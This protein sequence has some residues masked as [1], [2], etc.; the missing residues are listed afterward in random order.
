MPVKHSNDEYPLRVDD[1]DEAV[2]PDDKLS[3]PREFRIRNLVA[4]IG[5]PRKRFGGVNGKLGQVGGIGLGVPGD[6]L[7]GRFQVLDGGVSPD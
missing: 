4:P 5:E 7:D 2:G 1:V 3:E 6:E